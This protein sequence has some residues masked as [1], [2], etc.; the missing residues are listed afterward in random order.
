MVNVEQ[1]SDGQLLDLYKNTGRSSHIGTI[2]KRYSHV[3]LGLCY[4]YLKDSGKA[5]DAV[6]DIFE[7]VLQDVNKYDID[8]FRPWLMSVS[9]NHCLKM[10]TR[11]LRKEKELFDKNVEIFSLGNMETEDLLDHTNENMLIKLE[12]ALDSLKP[13]QR[14]CVTLFYLGGYSYEEISASS[15]YS[16]K[17]VKSYIQ[18]GKLNL[19][20]SLANSN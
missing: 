14:D 20:K 12:K 1:I 13:H 8:K 5:E 3:V 11:S 7:F 16:V 4:Q 6:M 2:F 9:R 18:N 15:G 19:K 10:L 17:S